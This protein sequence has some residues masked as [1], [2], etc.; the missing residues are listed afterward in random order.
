MKLLVVVVLSSLTGHEVDVT[1]EHIVSMRATDPDKGN[2]L[3]AEGVGCMI[4][5]SDGKYISVVQ[6]CEEVRK[7]IA[8]AKGRR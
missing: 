4:N 7:R 2:K 3:L 6:T 1:V 5:T 8:E